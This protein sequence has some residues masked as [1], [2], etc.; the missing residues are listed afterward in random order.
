MAP[1]KDN[2]GERAGDSGPQRL[3]VPDGPGEARAWVEL[4]LAEAADESGDATMSDAEWT[5]LAEEALGAK[6]RHPRAS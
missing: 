5:R 3:N 2:I 6:K 1:K 4:R